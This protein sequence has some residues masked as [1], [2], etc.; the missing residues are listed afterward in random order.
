MRDVEVELGP[1]PPLHF[2]LKL[3]GLGPLGAAKWPD[4]STDWGRLYS[5]GFRW[6]ICVAHAV[7]ATNLL[8]WSFSKGSN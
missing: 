8:R 6:V 2:V 4:P 3:E 5:I 1:C 7:L